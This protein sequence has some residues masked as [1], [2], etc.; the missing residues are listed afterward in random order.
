MPLKLCDFVGS[1]ERLAWANSNR[2]CPWNAR[3]C[4]LIARGGNLEVL[5][6]ARE[7]GCPWQEELAE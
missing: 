5:Q 3:T 7:H 2:V 6:W 4:A 1:V